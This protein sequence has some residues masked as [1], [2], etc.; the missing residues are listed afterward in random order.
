MIIDAPETAERLQ[1]HDVVLLDVRL[2]EDFAVE[3]IPG[4]VNQCVFEVLFLQALGEKG[5]RQDASVCVYGAGAD[6]HESQVAAEKLERA[7]FLQVLD[8]RG[9]L[10]A[11]IAEGRPVERQSPPPPE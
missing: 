4:A 2:P 5:I 9:G 6:S 10:E 1:R 8:F 3:H 11:W 7:G